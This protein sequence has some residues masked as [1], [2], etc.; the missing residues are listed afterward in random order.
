MRVH[1]GPW[2]AFPALQKKG[3]RATWAMVKWASELCEICA[4]FHHQRAKAPLG[5][6]FFSLEPGHSVF[7]DGIDPLPKRK[8]GAQYIHC[9]VDRATRLGDDMRMRDV[10]TA[11]VLRAF[12]HWI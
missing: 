12:Q 10:T 4:Q 2:K 3:S 6:H 7:G 1:W 5:Q 9:L 11:L 8:G